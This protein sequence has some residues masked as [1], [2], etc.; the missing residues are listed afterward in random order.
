[1]IGRWY[2]FWVSMGIEQGWTMQVAITIITV[3]SES[4]LV[5]LP[6]EV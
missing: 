3:V 6:D 5:L 2:V 4:H 1:M